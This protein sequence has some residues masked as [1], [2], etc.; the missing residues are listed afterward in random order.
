MS[1]TIISK[2]INRHSNI[3]CNLKVGDHL[4]RIH[5]LEHFNTA[6]DYEVK[7][8]YP[9][10]YLIKI[11]YRLGYSNSSDDYIYTTVSKASIY[12]GSVVLIKEDGKRVDAYQKNFS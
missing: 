11:K 4:R 10:L 5:G 12:C 1:N 2:A 6:Y 3:I 8:E 7:G 9:Y